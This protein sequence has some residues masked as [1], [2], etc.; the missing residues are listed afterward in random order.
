MALLLCLAGC[1]AYPAF[2]GRV[3]NDLPTEQEVR[4]E[5]WRG[6]HLAFDEDHTIP[7]GGEWDLGE[8]TRTEGDHVIRVHVG[9]RLAATESRFFGHDEGPGG[10]GVHLLA[11]GTTEISYWHY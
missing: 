6:D 5:V 4:I 8:F 10:F 3:I 7:A 11:N 2:E 9:G 1:S